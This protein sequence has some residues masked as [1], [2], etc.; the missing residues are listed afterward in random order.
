MLETKPEGVAFDWDGT[1]ADTRKAVVEALEY[2]LD[3][4][5]KADWDTT[6]K[7]YRDST[8][9]LKENFPNFFGEQAWEA[10]EMYLKYY[11][12]KA[13][14]HVTPASGAKEL[15]KML[16]SEGIKLCIVSNKEKSLI[17]SEVKHCFPDIKFHKIL[18]NGDA[19]KNKPAPDPIFIAFNDINITPQTV[20]MVGD[21]KQDTECAFA[22]GCLPILIGSGKLME[23]DYLKNN[24][25]LNFQNFTDFKNNI[26]I[27]N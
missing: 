26:H 21:T 7:K 11:N 5:G 23:D 17:L 2:V 10:Y 16:E 3:Q 13:Y 8:K 18:G 19:P 4:Y 14:I 25:I 22:A 20:W 24:P 1:L 12:D 27:K 9:S 15:L 6:K